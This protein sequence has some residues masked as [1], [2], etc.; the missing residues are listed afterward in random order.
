MPA[1]RTGIADIGDAFDHD[2]SNKDP[3]SGV[4]ARPRRGPGTGRVGMPGPRPGYRPPRARAAQEPDHPRAADD[5]ARAL[6]DLGAQQDQCHPARIQLHEIRRHREGARPVRLAGDGPPARPGRRPQAPG[7][8][9][10]LFRLPG[11]PDHGPQLHQGDV[12]LPR[13]ARQ[14]RGQADG[15]PRLVAPR[16]PGVHARVLREDGGALRQRPA[17][18]VRRDGVRPLGRVPHL[19]RARG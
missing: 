8:R 12:Q 11:Q 7:D 15:L 3:A 6:G 10:V 9:A 4:P 17:A 16:A 18:G 13:D 5:R 19:F 14:Q 1:L 2:R